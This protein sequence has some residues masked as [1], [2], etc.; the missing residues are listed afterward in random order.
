MRD[1]FIPALIH[2]RYTYLNILL[3]WDNIRREINDSLCYGTGDDDADVFDELPVQ[4]RLRRTKAYRNRTFSK[5]NSLQNLL[6]GK[7]PLKNKLIPNSAL[8]LKM[9]NLAQKPIPGKSKQKNSTAGNA[10]ER[11]SVCSIL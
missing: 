9:K 2:M 5:T 7:S 8:A 11:S 1:I 10:S 4:Y 6:D 3:S